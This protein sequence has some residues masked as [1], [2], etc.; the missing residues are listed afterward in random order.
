MYKE[1]KEVKDDFDQQGKKLKEART[2][3]KDCAE[4]LEIQAKF[5]KA[6]RTKARGEAREEKERMLRDKDKIIEMAKQTLWT[7]RL[8]LLIRN[9]R[10]MKYI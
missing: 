4:T 2:E 10:H 5:F 8:Q 6:E 7:S 9:G 3:I 1:H